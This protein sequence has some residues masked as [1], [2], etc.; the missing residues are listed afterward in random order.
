MSTTVL[1]PVAI[2]KPPTT[3]HSPRRAG[4]RLPLAIALVAVTLAAAGTGTWLIVA[5]IGGSGGSALSVP[6]TAPAWT[7]TATPLVERLQVVGLQR[8]LVRAGYAIKVDGDLDRVAKSALADYL[9]PN[10]AH[11]L[12]PFVASALGG[13]VITGL[14]NPAAWNSRFGPHPTTLVELSP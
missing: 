2:R 9:Q 10:E 13:T 8:Q 11:P 4:R 7:P 6:I 1:K 14:R 5:R 12:T 3:A